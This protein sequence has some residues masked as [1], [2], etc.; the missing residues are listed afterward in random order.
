MLN[1]LKRD[2]PRYYYRV[3]NIFI[4][5]VI[6]KIL[7][8]E[9]NYVLFLIYKEGQIV[10]EHDPILVNICSYLDNSKRKVGELFQK[11]YY[12]WSIL[13]QIRIN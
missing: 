4:S 5:P 2:E 11:G 10:C 9:I 3:L 13:N 6:F 7:A 8:K 1:L 12:I